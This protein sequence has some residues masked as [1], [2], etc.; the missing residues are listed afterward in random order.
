MSSNGDEMVEV[1][2]AKLTFH[3]ILTILDKNRQ[4]GAHHWLAYMLPS[5]V[6]FIKIYKTNDIRYS[7]REVI[8]QNVFVSRSKYVSAVHYSNALINSM[9]GKESD[10]DTKRG[11]FEEEIQFHPSSWICSTFVTLHI[12]TT[13]S[14]VMPSDVTAGPI[15]Q[16]KGNVAEALNHFDVRNIH[17]YNLILVINLIGNILKIDKNT[18]QNILFDHDTGLL[19]RLDYV[20]GTNTHGK[21]G[22]TDRVVF[23]TF[24]K[25]IQSGES[26]KTVL[27]NIRK[28]THDIRNSHILTEVLLMD[29]CE[30]FMDN[31]LWSQS[32]KKNDDLVSALHVLDN[33]SNTLKK[34]IIE[35]IQESFDGYR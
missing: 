30:Y 26:R 31:P 32:G 35:I 20:N 27:G 16:A 12:N 11:H 22:V 6:N 28:N 18:I 25:N 5:I 23:Q 8:L 2:L 24:H 13:G 15:A 1:G 33:G 17:F 21:S 10:P 34:T 19:Y 29:R 9:Y 4:D 7:V 14:V 3:E